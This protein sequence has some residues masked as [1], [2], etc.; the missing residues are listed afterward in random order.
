MELLGLSL[1]GIAL[2]LSPV[3]MLTWWRARPARRDEDL[4]V[5]DRDHLQHRLAQGLSS[6]ETLELLPTTGSSPIPDAYRGRHPVVVE[7]PVEAP[8]YR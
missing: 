1:I 6:A 8:R 2:M 3:A 4:V 7:P 5:V